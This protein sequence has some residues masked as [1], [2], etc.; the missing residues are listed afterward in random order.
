MFSRFN[1]TNSSRWLGRGTDSRGF[2]DV[3]AKNS[4]RSRIRAAPTHTA[5]NSVPRDRRD[6]PDFPPNRPAPGEAP[7]RILPP[8]RA[9]S[10]PTAGESDYP[11]GNG[12]KAAKPAR[13][14]QFRGHFP[15]GF[16]RKRG[17]RNCRP[18]AEHNP[19]AKLPRSPRIS[20]WN[21]NGRA[22]HPA[23]TSLK[24]NP[25]GNNP[26]RKSR[27]T[28]NI[29]HG[30]IVF[31]IAPVAAKIASKSE[32]KKP[33]QCGSSPPAVIQ[34]YASRAFFAPTRTKF[35]AGTRLGADRWI[36]AIHCE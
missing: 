34:R 20:P 32:P 23:S 31:A 30:E 33:V 22:F 9:R 12:T 29:S 13:G 10:P 35:P 25:R 5:G 4:E 24:L 36:P 7:R 3:P 2:H 18:P 27:T 1:W 28:P 8:K 17:N 26:P 21:R 15:R 6:P 19:S 11:R 16:G 14:A